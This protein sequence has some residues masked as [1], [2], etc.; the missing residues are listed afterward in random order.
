M[1]ESLRQYLNSINV[2]IVNN[3][4]K[5]LTDGTCVGWHCASTSNLRMNTHLKMIKKFIMDNGI[6]CEVVDLNENSLSFFILKN[7]L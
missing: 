6:G 2:R 1:N 5:S 3:V 7:D 4:R